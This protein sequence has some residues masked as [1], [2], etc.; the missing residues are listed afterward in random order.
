M[1]P[2]DFFVHHVEDAFARRA[3]QAEVDVHFKFLAQLDGAIDRFNIFIIDLQ[4]VVGIGPK[5]VVHR[6]ADPVE[7]PILNP[8]KIDFLKLSV[9]L[10]RKILHPVGVSGEIFQQVEAVPA[11]IAGIR[12]LLILRR[13][14]QPAEPSSRRGTRSQSFQYRAAID[15][16]TPTRFFVERHPRHLARGSLH[17]SAPAAQRTR[18][19][20][21]LRIV[22]YSNRSGLGVRERRVRL[23][24]AHECRDGAP[25]SRWRS[26]DRRAPRPTRRLNA[27]CA[28]S[29]PGT[30]GRTCAARFATHRRQFP[31]S[32]TISYLASR[33][34][35]RGRCQPGSL[36]T[37]QVSPY[38]SP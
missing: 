23:R 2:G 1:D 11:R 32:R 37:F 4:Q 22:K 9:I 38:S 18:I 12:D 24:A 7:S 21:T 19:V 34:R 30:A 3:V 20:D 15:C 17:S 29:N 16:W 26:F 27:V 13:S 35:N 25:A 8:F 5:T 33:W 36:S 28:P 31:G 14:R 6:K 10:V